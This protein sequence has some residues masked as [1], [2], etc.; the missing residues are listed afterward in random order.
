[1]RS[2]IATG[3]LLVNFMGHS[4]HDQWALEGLLHRN[5]SP[6][7]HNADRLPVVLSMTCYTGAFHHPPYAPLDETLVLQPGGGA[8]A[9]WGPT[10]AGV[11]EGH[12]HL[13][14]GFFDA[15]FAGGATTLGSAAHAGKLQ[16]YANSVLS[17]YLIDT[18][19]LLGD[20]A[21]IVDLD[22]TIVNKAHLPLVVR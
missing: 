2:A 14:R 17:Q 18:Y 13:A 6:S 15:F 4:S 10:G 12:F 20:P 21:T 3:T 19:V 22:A 8:L 1:V 11:S 5:Q 9:S 7:L 16:L